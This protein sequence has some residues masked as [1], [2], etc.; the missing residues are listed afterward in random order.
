MLTRIIPLLLSA[1]V[2]LGGHAQAE[3]LVALNDQEMAAQDA[4]EG[5]LLNL[6]LLNNMTRNS[7][8]ALVPDSQ[9]TAS[10]TAN[11]CRM[12][13]EIAQRGTWFMAK[14]FY[15]SLQIKDLRMDSGFLPTTPSGFQNYERFK[16]KD[17][18]GNCLLSGNP[19][20]CNPAGMAAIQAGY[21]SSN[22]LTPTVYDDIL[23]FMNIGRTWL[24][25]T[26]GPTEGY[27]RDTSPNSVFGIRLSDS[28]ALNEPA[29]MR[30]RGTA[31]VFGF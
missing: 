31:Y 20:G 28:R 24:E 17:T 30:F 15:G 26:N 8:G 2:L 19:A 9:C 6:S 23:S 25:F 13:L 10:I 29:H 21:P 1:G 14:E 5:V 16:D 11:P 22:D 3:G 4:R 27:M 12:G 7:S 18:G